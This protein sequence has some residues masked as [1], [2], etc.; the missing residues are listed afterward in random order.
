MSKFNCPVDGKDGYRREPFFVN[1]LT[2]MPLEHFYI[3]AHYQDT[4]G[5]L[6]I[7]SGAIHDRIEKLAYD[8]I[9]DYNG[10]TVHLICVLK[11]GAT[12]F[13]DLSS[14]MKKFHNYNREKYIP[15]TFDFIR[16]KSY[17][18]TSS[19]GNVK[20]D[21]IDVSSLAGKHVLFVED[22]IDT[23]LTMSRLL[24]YLKDHVKPASIR[25]A[26]LLEKRTERSCG[27]KADYVG[28]SVP[29]E[30]AVGYCLDYNE[31][32]RDLTHIGVI[33]KAGI[34]KFRDYETRDHTTAAKEE[35]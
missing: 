30:F 31:A 6:M 4:L 11:G 12:F 28:F 27:F 35:A 16:V 22:I 5:G 2:S 17:E 32:Y 19:T 10:Q 3:P 13:S 21:N 33:N 18:G 23:G 34:E 24:A 25:V 15:Y 14:A 7:A 9:Q 8:I 29:D 20:I 26:S 1:D